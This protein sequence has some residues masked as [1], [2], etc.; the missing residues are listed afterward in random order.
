L[1]AIAVAF[2]QDMIDHMGVGWTFTLLG[3]L[4]SLSGTLFFVERQKGMKWRLARL[5]SN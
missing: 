5:A 1:A 3:S 2:L 4:C